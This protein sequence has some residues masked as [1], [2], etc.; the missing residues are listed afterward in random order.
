MTLILEV[1]NFK[2][3]GSEGS[4]TFGRPT[5][6]F[7]NAS[8]RLVLRQI[9][10]LLDGNGVES[11]ILSQPPSPIRSR[12]TE[13]STRADQWAENSASQEAFATQVSARLRRNQ[14]GQ[15][16]VEISKPGVIASLLGQ[17]SKKA[18]A[19][20]QNGSSST[21]KD[22]P[23]VPSIASANARPR[24]SVLGAVPADR[25]LE[26]TSKLEAKA[27]EQ[28]NQCSASQRNEA[29]NSNNQ[30]V[31]VKGLELEDMP[32]VSFDDNE[33]ENNQDD[34]EGKRPA[35]DNTKFEPTQPA[36]FEQEETV[37][38]SII[39]QFQDGNPFQGLKRVPRRYT[40]IQGS[41]QSLLESM[42][43]WYAPVAT[44]RL[45]ANLPANVRDDLIVFSG[46]KA[47]LN[48]PNRGCGASEGDSDDSED[49]RQSQHRPRT[50]GSEESEEEEGLKFAEDQDNQRKPT[51]RHESPLSTVNNVHQ[52]TTVQ[53]SAT[54]SNDQQELIL[55]SRLPDTAKKEVRE[56]DNIS[57]EESV[58][59][60]PSPNPSKAIE[61]SVESYNDEQE[62]ILSSKLPDKA[63]KEVDEND[64]MSEEESVPWTPSPDR[65]KAIEQSIESCNDHSSPNSDRE[66]SPELSGSNRQSPTNTPPR[67]SEPFSHTLS[68]FQNNKRGKPLQSM[69]RLRT[70]VV[71]PSS[72]PV[73]EEEL[74]F[75]IPYAI[76]DV[77]VE[78]ESEEEEY[79]E[80]FHRPP[81]TALQNSELVQVEQTPVPQLRQSDGKFPGPKQANDALKESKRG[82]NTSS[83]DSRIPATCEALP[84]TISG[85][86]K[87]YGFGN[88]SEM[89]TLTIEYLN[90]NFRQASHVHTPF[91][92]R[93]NDEDDDLAQGQLFSEYESSQLDHVASS[94]IRSQAA[95]SFD[96]T[97]C[98]QEPSLEKPVTVATP[99]RNSTVHV[100]GL[101]SSALRTPVSHQ[102]QFDSG[103]PVTAGSL[104]R[105]SNHLVGRPKNPAKRRRHAQMACRM[106]EAEVNIARDPQELSRIHRYSFD[107][108]SPRA[109]VDRPIMSTDFRPD[110]PRWKQVIPSTS[111]AFE[112]TELPSP[113]P[114]LQSSTSS[115]MGGVQHVPASFE[116]PTSTVRPTASEDHNTPIQATGSGDQPLPVSLMQKMDEDCPSDAEEDV[117][118]LR[119]SLL[120]TTE[121]AIPSQIDFYEEF[122]QIYPGYL[123][124]KNAFT[125]ALVNI[126]WIRQEQLFLPWARYDDFIRVLASD[127]LDYVDKNR[128]LG[129]KLMSGLKYYM[130]NFPDEP[131]FRYK[132][133]TAENLQD[134]LVSLDAEKVAA[135]RVKYSEPLKKEEAQPT[136]PPKSVSS[137]V[138]VASKQRKANLKLWE[139]SSVENGYTATALVNEETPFRCISRDA[140]PELGPAN[141]SL[142]TASHP[143]AIELMSGPA[144]CSSDG[145]L[146]SY[147]HRSRKP[148]FETH[149]QLPDRHR[150]AETHPSGGGNVAVL[151]SSGRKSGGR[152]ALPWNNEDSLGSSI[153]STPTLEGK[154]STPTV[155]VQKSRGRPSSADERNASSSRSRLRISLGSP[156]PVPRSKFSRPVKR[157]ET[158]SSGAPSRDLGVFK[159]R[160]LPASTS[161]F[162]RSNLLKQPLKPATL[163]PGRPMLQEFLA[164]RRRSGSIT[165]TTP[166]KRFCT[167]PVNTPSKA[168]QLE[169]ETQGWDARD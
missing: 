108:N 131:I 57:D 20:K 70:P 130:E 163:T 153:I 93:E 97:A 145:S 90:D 7:R 127:W 116:E 48:M 110:S 6:I 87:A 77:V 31:S 89:R 69:R 133:I 166:G 44:D 109:A 9:E 167:K 141:G 121:P 113:Q 15:A 164:R 73:E 169:P 3:R 149:S 162:S 154:T 140:S 75:A 135:Y 117:A 158:N 94:S 14:E 47:A 50:Y 38:M 22:A 60:T 61:Q 17:F 152:R 68:H 51:I 82:V 114:A 100:A 76:G 122:M 96:I 120:P 92:V 147:N 4:A 39:D 66:R 146:N 10:E 54:N 106:I 45:Y 23:P 27:N 83:S 118:I 129:D 161:S 24:K 101:Q 46:G 62:L 134:A 67:S 165:Q 91:M 30:S 13:V 55:S 28:S 36:D 11:D 8:I 104:K 105:D 157:V 148:F 99:P 72:S 56:N 19:S 107:D 123:G 144:L 2:F 52:S 16:D 71:I 37:Q 156:N 119:G 18:S 5:E 124:S 155:S 111:P 1:S 65:S 49:G 151:S 132:F 139:H 115:T 29:S 26:M 138:E 63:N 42:D 74:E 143:V 142:F 128:E 150:Q 136:H 64:N 102:D 85:S 40:R 80:S 41:Q 58:P 35:T 126:E 43:S 59:W 33:K 159:R 32:V 78:N 84:Q 112:L 25:V 53:N 168:V 88:L 81:S 95:L 86:N 103:S 125:R 34:L 98:T 12:E 160:S 137:K 21:A 79:S